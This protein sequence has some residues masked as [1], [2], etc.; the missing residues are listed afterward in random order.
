MVNNKNCILHETMT[1]K[2]LHNAIIVD[3]ASTATT[4]LAFEMHI[5]VH[6]IYAT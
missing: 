6:N 4:F 5:K 3:K 2:V 1:T